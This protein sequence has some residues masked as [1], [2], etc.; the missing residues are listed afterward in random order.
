MDPNFPGPLFDSFGII[1]AVVASFVLLGFVLVFGA[2]I[3]RAVRYARA[4]PMHGVATCVAKRTEVSGSGGGMN[5][6]T[7]TMDMA[8]SS[9]TYRAT[10]ELEDGQRMELLLDGRQY[11][12]LAEGDRGIL[13]WRSDVFQGF[14]R[15][16]ESRRG[17]ISG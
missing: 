16:P 8:H 7:G 12:M 14:Q 3:W 15:N 17:M 10:F 1:F 4:T 2:I 6:S 11:G 9:T 13:N 5:A